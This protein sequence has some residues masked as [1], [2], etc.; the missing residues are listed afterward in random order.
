VIVRDH[1]AELGYFFLDPCNLH[2]GEETVMAERIEAECARAIAD[3]AP[4]RSD[5]AGRNRRW[6][7]K[8]PAWPD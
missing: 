5:L 1:E 2:P 7:E 3:P 8:P 6:M 4:T